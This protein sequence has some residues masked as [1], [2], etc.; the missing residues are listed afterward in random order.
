MTDA[1]TTTATPALPFRLERNAHGHLVHISAEGVRSEQCVPVR[2]F[3]LAAPDEGVSLIGTDGHELVWIDR[4]SAL[5]DG[6][7]QLLEAELAQRE[8]SPEI[9]RIRAVSTFS[10]PTTWDVETD[11]GDTQLVLEVEENIRRLGGGALLVADTRGVHFRIRDRFALDKAS[12]RFLE[13]FL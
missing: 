1:T 8:F 10:T 9:L 12:R 6:P 11:R 13:R 4:L 5:P 7:R 2:A 3:P